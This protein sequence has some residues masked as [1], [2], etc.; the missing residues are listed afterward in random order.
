MTR[1]GRG[2]YAL[3]LLI[4]ALLMA[5]AGAER[6]DRYKETVITS[7][8]MSANDLQQVTTYTGNVLLNKGSI[9]VRAEKLEVKRD[10]E[11]YDYAT[12]FAGPG[13]LAY[14][15]QKREGSDEYI[16]GVAERIEY[17]GKAETAKFFNRAVMKRLICEKAADEVRGDTI[18][19]DQK[20]DIYTA[21]GGPQAAT[22]GNRVR[23]VL[24][25]KTQDP[26]AAADPAKRADPCRAAP[27]A[28]PLK[29]STELERQ[30]R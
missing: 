27:S 17:D 1:N 2:A 4:L 12:A 29:P 23:A 20:T 30:A 24:Q 13:K 15:R 7:N 5:P 25:P 18:T 28:A 9:V 14:F 6:A 16:E 21:S 11:G 26:S 10:P 3:P 22:P 8:A 19:Y